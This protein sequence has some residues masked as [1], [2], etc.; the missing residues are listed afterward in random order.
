LPEK[1]TNKIPEFYII[2]APKMPEFYI[3]IARKIFSPEFW[4]ARA[5]LPLSTPMVHLFPI[6]HQCCKFGEYLSYILRR[7]HANNVPDAQM[8]RHINRTE[9]DNASSSTTLGEGVTK[10]Q[11]LHAAHTQAGIETSE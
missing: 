6:M 11:F 10:S 3:I 5:P 2:F 4:G 7:H 8:Q 1:L 9:T